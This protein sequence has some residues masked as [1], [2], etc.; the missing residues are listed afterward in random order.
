M[1]ITPKFRN[2]PG[3]NR[4]LALGVLWPL[5]RLARLTDNDLPSLP[6]TQHDDDAERHGMIAAV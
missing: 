3:D 2:M 1:S 4:F 5:P 6:E